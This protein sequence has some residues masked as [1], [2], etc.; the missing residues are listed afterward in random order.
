[1]R[2]DPLHL[3]RDRV[4]N[5]DFTVVFLLPSLEP[6]QV[7]YKHN[8]LPLNLN[9]HIMTLEL[10]VKEESRMPCNKQIMSVMDKPRWIPTVQVKQCALIQE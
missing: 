6:R 3:S 8:S 4:R 2:N 10:Q 9:I 1:V 5:E 7:R